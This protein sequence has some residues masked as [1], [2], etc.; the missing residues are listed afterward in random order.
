MCQSKFYDF[1]DVILIHF[2]QVLL[3]SIVVFNMLVM[4]R[5]YFLLGLLP[6]QW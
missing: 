2:P 1:Y 3:F 4:R 5:K 6:G